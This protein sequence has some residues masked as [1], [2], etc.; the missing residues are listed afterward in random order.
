MNRT[1]RKQLADAALAQVYAQIPEVH[2]K[3]FCHTTCGPIEMST[4][5]REKIRENHGIDIPP[6]PPGV[7]L[8]HVEYVD[9]AALTEDK[10]CGVYADRPSVCRMWGSSELLPCIYGCEVDGEP[11]SAV[12]EHVLSVAAYDAGGW[13]NN[14]RP[15]SDTSPAAIRRRAREHPELLIMSRA[16][17]AHGIRYDRAR[18]IQYGYGA[19]LVPPVS[20]QD[21]GLPQPGTLADTGIPAV[22]L[23]G[24]LLRDR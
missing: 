19:H 11:V 1:R 15:D 22:N 17:H 18:A 20:A 24:G 16:E 9:C 13:P 6:N 10:R 5:E 7:P 3:G 14:G 2:C 4:R 8:R 12:E 23:P 21:H